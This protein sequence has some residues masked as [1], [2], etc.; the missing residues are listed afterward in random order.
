MYCAAEVQLALA[1]RPPL[2]GGDGEGIE[3][4]DGVGDDAVAPFPMV[5]WP[6]GSNPR[7]SLPMGSLPTLSN[8]P[9][10]SA[11]A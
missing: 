1:G 3:T 9:W 4:E 7:V 10:A 6:M 11:A 2:S 5:S 8:G